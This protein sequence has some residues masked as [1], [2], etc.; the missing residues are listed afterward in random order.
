ME[1]GVAI[2]ALVLAAFAL[3]GTLIYFNKQAHTPDNT[4]I[5][6]I[7]G[8]EFAIDEPSSGN[9][10][11][12]QNNASLEPKKIYTIEMI[13]SGFSPDNLQISRGDSVKFVN[14]DSSPSW[15][16]AIGVDAS[17][18]GTSEEKYIF[19]SCKEISEGESYAFVFGGIGNWK[20]RD[21]LNPENT[22]TISVK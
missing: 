15:P 7:S 13:S 18:C 12:I 3:L 10:N 11:A 22:G 1:K 2:I 4:D 21:K 9:S 5:F 6:S 14:M 19:D 17:Q 16:E 20:Y 8:G